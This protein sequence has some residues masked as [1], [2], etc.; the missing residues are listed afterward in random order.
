MRI[1]RH[2]PTRAALVA[3]AVGLLVLALKLAAA[4]RTGSL[5]LLSDALESVVNVVAAAVAVLAVGIAARPADDNHPFGHAKVEYLSAGLEG[6][7][8]MV[9]AVTIAW[10]AL[11]RFG[12]EPRIPELGLGLAISGVATVLN[13][14]LAVYLLRSGRRH[15]S[16]ALLTDALH[17]QSDVWTSV[18]AYAG[19]GV[20]WATG[21]WEL[22]A[23]VAMGVAGHILFAGLGALRSSVGGLMDEGLSSAEVGA[24]AAILAA[25]GPPVIEHHDLRTRRAGKHLFVELHLV[26]AGATTVEAAHAICDRIESS[27]GELHPVAHVTIHVEPEGEARGGD[28]PPT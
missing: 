12:R 6:A 24:I 19:F 15:H 13:A 23:L 4:W 21:V 3:L 17:V 27:I 2:P 26:V 25:E 20:A 9:A 22:D 8:V 11:E 10:Q 5:T 18:G 1:V 14:L 28:R 16:P 7:L